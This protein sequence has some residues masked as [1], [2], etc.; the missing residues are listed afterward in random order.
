[1]RAFLYGVILQWKLDIRNK[2]IIITYY[3]VPLLFF[4]F[5]GMIFSSINPET[6]DTLIQSMTIFAITMGSYLGT[7]IPLVELYSGEIKKAYRVGNIPLWAGAVYNFLSAFV[8]LLITSVIIFLVAPLVFDAKVPTNLSFYFISLAMF[9]LVCLSVGTVLGLFIKSSS[10]LTMYSQLLF[11]PSMMLS[12]IM[13]PVDMLPE[14]MQIAGNVFP[15]TWG[16][17][18]LTDTGFH[19]LLFV[20]LI[21][22][23][24]L[25]IILSIYRLSKIGID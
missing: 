15:A 16:M 17:K 10:K 12:G 8:H 7:P 18:I 22:I 1:M 14:A 13:F 3:L 24:L 6:K 9:I 2:G 11:L 5:I 23:M 4:G 19:F 25:A 21:V 20:P